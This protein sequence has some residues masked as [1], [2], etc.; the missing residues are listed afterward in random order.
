MQETRVKKFKNM[1][2][3]NLMIKIQKSLFVS[4]KF[5]I[6]D[7]LFFLVENDLKK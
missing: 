3:K 5:R 1:V 2:L 7:F 6:P 4:R